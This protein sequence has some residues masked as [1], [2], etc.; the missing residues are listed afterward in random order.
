M[1]I[2]CLGLKGLKFKVAARYAPI[3]AI[4]LG[5]RVGIRH[6]TKTFDRKSPS[7]GTK[8]QVKKRQIDCNI[9]W[10]GYLI[11]SVPR[12]IS[13]TPQPHPPQK[14]GPPLLLT[15]KTLKCGLQCLQV[16]LFMVIL[17]FKIKIFS[18]IQF[19]IF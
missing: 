4:T 1:L 16:R 10:T 14:N 13:E 12:L 15:G 11:V 19:K 8:I 7:P 9:G 3:N 17:N 6:L 2:N 5:G 18:V